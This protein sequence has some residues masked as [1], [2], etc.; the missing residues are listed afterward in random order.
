MEGAPPSG[1][2]GRIKEAMGSAGLG[3]EAGKETQ[4]GSGKTGGGKEE[5]ERPHS[6]ASTSSS[7]ARTLGHFASTSMRL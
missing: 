3:G 6:E 4:K 1:Q 2:E 7:H 5:A